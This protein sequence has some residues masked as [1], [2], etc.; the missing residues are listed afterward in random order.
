MMVRFGLSCLTTAGLMLLTFGAAAFA[1]LPQTVAPPAPVKTSE[2]AK[3]EMVSFTKALE[4]L[5]RRYGIAFIADDTPLMETVPAAL[6]NEAL[7]NPNNLPRDEAAQ[8][9]VQKVADAFEYN[10]IRLGTTFLLQKNYKRSPD[11]FSSVTFEDFPNVTFEECVLATRDA[12]RAVDSLNPRVPDFDGVN[13]P[14]GD[15]FMMSLTQDQLSAMFNGLTNVTST[16]M[17]K[18]IR[19]VT[20][21]GVPTEG[22]KQKSSKGTIELGLPVRSLTPAQRTD[23]ERIAAYYFIQSPSNNIEQASQML[24]A[25][26]NP[27]AV[28]RFETAQIPGGVADRVLG[29]AVPPNKP[30][31]KP[32]WHDLFDEVDPK[33][34]ATPTPSAYYEAFIQRYRVVGPHDTGTPPFA[35]ALLKQHLADREAAMRKVEESRTRILETRNHR[36]NS[37]AETLT[38]ITKRLNMRPAPS[39]QPKVRVAVDPALA[40]KRVTLVG[41]QNLSNLSVWTGVSRLYDLATRETPDGSVLLTRPRPKVARTF[42]EVPDAMAHVLPQPLRNVSGSAFMNLRQEAQDRFHVIAAKLVEAAPTGDVAVKDLDDEAKQYLSLM[43]MN[44][45]SYSMAQLAEPLPNAITHFD[46]RIIVGGLVLNKKDEI[47]FSFFLGEEIS[48]GVLGQGAGFGGA[49][50]RRK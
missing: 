46:D 26:A 30:G 33:I 39:G 16:D 19:G 23:V 40:A 32:E 18:P 22:L 47:I 42:A 34:G 12:L 7:Q 48:P 25:L 3:S 5:S 6:L 21:D 20:M 8:Q 31:G 41:E 13:Y 49:H 38:Q 15:H 17:G 37:A 10:P 45:A 9:T 2:L 28:L 36:K 43:L 35:P 44:Y 27:N 29:C 11:G 4:T 14:L 1:A 24:E 50:Y